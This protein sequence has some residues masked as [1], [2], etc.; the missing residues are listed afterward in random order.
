MSLI[1]RHSTTCTTRLLSSQKLQS[2]WRQ[3]QKHKKA[4]NVQ[5]SEVA[6]DGCKRLLGDGAFDLGLGR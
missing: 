4:Y 2:S 3:T 6:E 5:M 1:K